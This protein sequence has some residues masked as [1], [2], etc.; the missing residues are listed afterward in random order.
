MLA[1]VDHE[2]ARAPGL[3]V[4]VPAAGLGTRMGAP[5][6][7]QYLRLGDR[8]VIEHTLAVF[9]AH[10]R[11]A[12]LIVALARDDVYWDCLG[13]SATKPLVR[14]EGG[15]ERCHT[16]LNALDALAARQGPEAWVLVHD[17]AR[18]CL[19]AED[20]DRLLDEGLRHRVGA[21]LATPARDTIK[22]VDQA[23]R[24]VETVDRRLLWQ[25]LTPQLF[26]LGMLREALSGALSQGRL[27]TDESSAIELLGESPIVVEGTDDNLKVTR[28]ADL[29]LA[30]MILIAQGRLQ[31]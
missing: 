1:E 16:V 18:P 22:R 17:A 15:A 6:P 23:G 24:V 10:P 13:L 14:V 19:R 29:E 5:R 28:P 21:L 11:I 31:G 8:T 20:L 27:V 12:G 9:D 3:W 2:G 25:A 7:K 30:R 4:V 26:R